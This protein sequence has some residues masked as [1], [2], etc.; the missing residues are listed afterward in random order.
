[1]KRLLITLAL[2]CFFSSI[3]AQVDTTIRRGPYKFNEGMAVGTDFRLLFVQGADS[4]AVLVVDSDGNIDTI[5]TSDLGL[6]EAEVLAVVRANVDTAGT[7]TLTEVLANGASTSTVAEFLTR[8]ITPNIRAATSEGMTISNLAGGN[9]VVFGSDESLNTSF[10]GNLSMGNNQIVSLADPNSA[11]DAVNLG[12]LIGYVDTAAAEGNINLQQ[13][14]DNGATTSNEIVANGGVKTNYVE[15][16]GSGGLQLRNQSGTAVLTLGSGGAVNGTMAGNLSMDA[17][18]II[19]LQDP[20]SAQDAATKAYVDANA[21]GGGGGY[22]DTIIISGGSDTIT[23]ADEGV[24][25]LSTAAG[26]DTLYLAANLDLDSISEVYFEKHTS[27]DLIIVGG[28]TNNLNGSLATTLI[29]PVR[30][31]GFI[32]CLGTIS[33]A[34]RFSAIGNYTTD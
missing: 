15:A 29:V 25:F 8:I 24:L 22:T 32:R 11:Q 23:N 26:E 10:F 19:S 13:V 17:N 7:L 14:T 21:G 4:I 31:G 1:M 2:A 34:I 3:G 27:G 6:T 20:V 16:N 30:G 33:G 12:Y 18:R 5:P 28:L 9:V